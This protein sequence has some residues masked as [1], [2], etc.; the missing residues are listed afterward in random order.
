MEKEQGH[1]M[2]PADSGHG[3]K[4]VHKG[5][6]L[7]H[8][9]LFAGIGGIE[10]GLARAG[11]QT[12]SLAETDPAAY[13][14]LKDRFPDTPITGDVA[15]LADL[16]ADVDLLT[17]GFPCQNIS[18]AGDKAGINGDRSGV[19][20]HVFELL[21][22]R[23]V[24]WLLF[25]NVYFLLYVKQGRSMAYLIDR[26][27]RLGYRWAYRIVNS[28]WFGVPQRRRRLFLV[29]SMEGDPQNV[30]LADDASIPKEPER[31]LETPLGFYWTEGRSG[32]GFAVDAV[33]PLKGGSG[34]GIPSPPAV[35]FPDG[36]VVKPSIAV[37]ERIQGFEAGWTVAAEKTSS[38][39]ARWRL[40][41]NAVTVP[42]AEW[43]GRRLAQPGSYDFS[44]DQPLLESAPW[45][46]AAW[47]ESGRRHKSEVSERPL[48][49]G[50]PSLDS[51]VEL[52]WMP[53]SKR[54]TEGF[55]ARA[56][57]GNLRFPEGF[58][59]ALRRHAAQAI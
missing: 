22:R 57:E 34:V 41:G 2:L 4:H 38:R 44:A 12:T 52:E 35:F 46:K 27:E 6:S 26:L 45:P 17:A 9:G 16:P 39:G 8:V 33:P 47:G 7:L 3:A 31:T 56:S 49:M 54:A 58:L 42:V 30:L 43:I 28:F 29:A 37:A 21:E 5:A 24:P 14:V 40:V 23:R 20:D 10:A 53:L 1:I 51:F 15:T 25:E 18:M 32:V 48:D 59:T 11:H 55:V 36:R 13:A 50:I 19:I